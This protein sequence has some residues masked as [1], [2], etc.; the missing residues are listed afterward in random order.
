MSSYDCFFC[1]KNL[2]EIG[3]EK[4]T[5]DH[6]FKLKT[7]NQILHYLK[8][9]QKD[10]LFQD[11]IC[12]ECKAIS[13]NLAEL[14]VLLETTQMKINYYLNLLTDQIPKKDAQLNPNIN[15]SSFQK[16]FQQQCK[17]HKKYVKLLF[18]ITH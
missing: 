2:S 4:E 11:K 7:I 5:A 3:Q 14:C 8:A 10:N 15:L 9:P 1:C 13:D 6:V 16:L 12:K 18:K 17:L